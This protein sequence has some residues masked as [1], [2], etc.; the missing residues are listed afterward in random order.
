MSFSS[1]ARSSSSQFAQVTDR[2][3]MSRNAF[4]C[5]GDHSSQ[6]H[7]RHFGDS[8]FPRGFESEMT[9]NNFAIAPDQAVEF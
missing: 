6:K 5:A 3:T 2:F 1:W 4:T 8:E 7:H 9:I